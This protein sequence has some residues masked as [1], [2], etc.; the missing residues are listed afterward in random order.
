MIHWP[1]TVTVRRSDGT[2]VRLRPLR[3][4]DRAEWEAL[5]ARN[6][7]WLRPWEATLPTGPEPAARYPRL[8]RGYDRAAREGRLVPF[9]V[10]VDG[11][12]VGQCHL[13]DF[14]W[15]SRWTAAVGYWLD[16]RATGRGVATTALAAALV[17]GLRDVGLHRIE[18]H[19]R[20]ENTASLAVVTRLGLREE[21]LRRGLIHVDGAWRDHVTYVA[22]SG[23]LP[24]LTAWLDT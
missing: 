23:D 15:G 21:G 9:A 16:E 10:E 14:L 1:T 19:V 20:P 17:H 2:V 6:A 22:D 13:F 7:A 5:R 24:A 8:R 11:A 3:R 4:T 12:L 18:V